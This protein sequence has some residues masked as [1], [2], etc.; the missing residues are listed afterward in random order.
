MSI[1]L[2]GLVSFHFNT[3]SNFRACINSN[4]FA[5][6]KI[7]ELDATF[8]DAF[9]VLSSAGNFSESFF[10]HR[11]RSLFLSA[12]RIGCG[13]QSADVYPLV[14]TMIESSLYAWYINQDSD[15]FNVWIKRMDDVQARNKARH[16]FSYGKIM[17]EY[18]KAHPITAKV[19]KEIYD[20][21]IDNG[22]HPNVFSVLSGMKMK[23]DDDSTYIDCPLIHS[24]D[25]DSFHLALLEVARAGVGS[26]EIFL[27][28]FPEKFQ[29]NG[30]DAKIR[31]IMD[32]L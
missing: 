9:K 22:A 8:S 5:V 30:L 31:K 4:V 17:N 14:R 15:R 18:E 16:L 32:G 11:C 25:S 3:E 27:N 7:K 6:S 19:I 28:T 13:G 24:W 29:A 23:E 26:L 1:E 20:F 2:E 12:V 10:L 21:H